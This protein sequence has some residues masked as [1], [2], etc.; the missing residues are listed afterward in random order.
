[1]VRISATLQTIS[2]GMMA[3]RT[4]S[5]RAQCKRTELQFGPSLWR[6]YEQSLRCYFLQ[7]FYR[8]QQSLWL[9]EY[10][11]VVRRF[12]AWV[13]TIREAG[14]GFEMYWGGSLWACCYQGSWTA[15]HPIH[16]RIVIEM[17]SKLRSKQLRVHRTVHPTKVDH[18]KSLDQWA[19]FDCCKGI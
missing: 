1:M 2:C 19:G 6:H 10:Q 5:C 7:E 3:I 8:K 18:G 16:V 9:N 4:K 12:N 11:S 14:F 17:T 13:Y 15:A